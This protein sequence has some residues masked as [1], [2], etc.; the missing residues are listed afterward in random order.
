[1]GKRQTYRSP[2][3]VPAT[4]FRVRWLNVV[5]AVV[6]TALTFAL[7]LAWLNIATDAPQ[8]GAGLPPCATEDSTG[9]YWDADTRG[10]GTGH[11]VVTLENGV[12]SNLTPE[13]R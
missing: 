2:A 10:N 7:C 12:S 6:V 1:M 3:V 9:C 4:R 13:G 11:D 8:P 5:L